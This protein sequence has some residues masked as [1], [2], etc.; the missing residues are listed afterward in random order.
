MNASTATVDV[1]ACPSAEANAVEN[2]LFSIDIP[3]EDTYVFN[4]KLILANGDDIKALLG[5]SL[6]D[7]A[8]TISYL[9]L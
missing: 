1:H 3:S 6:T 2:L 5:S 4:D 9:D 7:V 8:C